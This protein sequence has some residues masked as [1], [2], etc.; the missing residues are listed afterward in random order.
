VKTAGQPHDAFIILKAESQKPS[1][2]NKKSK[3]EEKKK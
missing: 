1:K 2:K 3:D